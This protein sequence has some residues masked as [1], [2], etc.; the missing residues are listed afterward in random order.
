MTEQTKRLE[1]DGIRDLHDVGREPRERVRVGIGRLV[2]C[3]MAAVI[4]YDHGV[5]ARQRGNMVCE[6]LLRPTET[7]HEQEARTIARPLDREPD[8]VVRCD[9]H[10]VML[11]RRVRRAP[12]GTGSDRHGT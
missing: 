10:P 4:E 11:T 3:A 12:D 5:I 9:A 2:A 8:T 1:T 7:V 6:I